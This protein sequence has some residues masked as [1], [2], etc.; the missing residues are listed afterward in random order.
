MA[1]ATVRTKGEKVP[2]YKKDKIVRKGQHIHNGRKG[3]KGFRNRSK[4]QRDSVG[5][6]KGKGWAKTFLSRKFNKSSQN[7]PDVKFEVFEVKP[8]VI[9]AY[10]H[11]PIS[12]GSCN[13]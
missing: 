5:A 6:N 7:Y 4:A 9:E 1:Q 2:N 8:I 3:A 13:F 11:S 12:G 10:P